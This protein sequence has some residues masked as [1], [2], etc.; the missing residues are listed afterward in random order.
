MELLKYK[1]RELF[2]LSAKEMAEEP[3][4][5]FFTNL[6]IYAQI[7]KKQEKEAKLWHKRTSKP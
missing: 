4:D 3:I 5:Q 7:S 2:H 6:Y 1:Y